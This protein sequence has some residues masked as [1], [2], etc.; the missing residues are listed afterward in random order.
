MTNRRTFLKLSTGALGAGILA[1][2]SFAETDRVSSATAIGEVF[3]H[4][5]RLTGVAL[6]Y[7]SPRESLAL[8][9]D[10]YAIE[11]RKVVNVFTSTSTDPADAAPKGKFVIVMLDPE[12]EGAPLYTTN[13]RDITI[14]PMEAKI[15]TPSGEITTDTAKRLLVD[16]FEQ[17]VYMDLEN[18]ILLQYNLFVP[19]D[20][21]PAKSY[22]L[23]NF[24]HDAS[25]TSKE[26]ERTLVQGLG[27]VVWTRPEEQAKRPCFVLAP[28]FD[29]MVANNG[30]ET[31]DH[32]DTVKRVIEDLA[33]NYNIDMNRLY[34]TGQSG[35]G[36]L[37]VAMNIKHPDFFAA[38]FLVACQWGADLVKPMKN[39]SLFIL[40]AAED[41]KAKPGQ[42]AL[43]EALEG[44]GA[45]VNRALWN[46][47]W[48]ATEF[49]RAYRAMV[50]EGAQINYVVL[51][52]GTVI[53]DGADTG[54]AAGHINTWPIA[55]TIEGIREWLFEQSK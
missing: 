5:L 10:D 24:M 30:T 35:G 7:D 25:V 47:R 17:R 9:R 28:Q 38:S 40:V 45:T 1:E 15:T 33:G 37:S 53:P 42:D 44:Y 41:K 36:M 14:L 52:E 29:V 22:P 48:S 26:P 39:D 13:G 49:D 12:D 11:G 50:A 31:T 2:V 21:D 18:G 20:Y 32:K 4:G 19:R 27:A 34:N 3:G 46:G 55:Y 23:V 43:I 8:S 16:E 51:K 6:E 54:G